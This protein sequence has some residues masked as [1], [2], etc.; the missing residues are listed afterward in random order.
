MHNVV[1]GLLLAGPMS[2]YDLH[3]A[4]RDG[5]AHFYAA[6]FGSLQRTLTRLA[7]EGLIRS[8]DVPIGRR[9]RR[10]H[11]LTDAGR[12]AF[13]EWMTA[14]VTGSDAETV[15]LARVFFL[16]NVDPQTRAGSLRAVRDRVVADRETLEQVMTQVTA[17]IREIPPEAADIARFRIAT[18]EYGLRAHRLAEDW[19]D[20]LD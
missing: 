10:E 11:S 9:P 15:M 1:L 13:E 6:S 2:M 14:P 20:A 16:G 8:V 12:R 19:L 3:K 5:I 4:F 18:L 7:A 17:S